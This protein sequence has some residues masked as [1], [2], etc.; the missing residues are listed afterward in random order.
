[1][2]RITILAWMLLLATAASADLKNVVDHELARTP[3]KGV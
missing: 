2:H 3:L 1:M